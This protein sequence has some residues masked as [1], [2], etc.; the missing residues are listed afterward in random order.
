MKIKPTLCRFAAIAVNAPAIYTSAELILD[1]TTVKKAFIMKF[2]DLTPED[3]DTISRKDIILVDQPLADDGL[4]TQDEQAEMMR[5]IIERY[6]ASRVLL[7]T[8]Y[9]NSMNYRKIFPDVFVWDNL[10][11]QPA[12]APSRIWL[13]KRLCI[14]CHTR[15]K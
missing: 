10:A 3:A 11:C 4:I 9:R 14:L 5:R 7:K 12:Y 8:H 2:F 1:C 6:G 15:R 13:I